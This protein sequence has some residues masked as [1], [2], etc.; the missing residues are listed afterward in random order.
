MKYSYL[1]YESPELI[2]AEIRTDDP[3]PHLEVGHQLLLTTDAYPGKIGTALI[4]EHVR[5]CIVQ[6]RQILTQYEVHVFC[7]EQESPHPL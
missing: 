5:I 7:R 6:R 3:L 4:V 1:I 2:A